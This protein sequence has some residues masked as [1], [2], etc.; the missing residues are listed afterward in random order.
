MT[1]L[2]RDRVERRTA[3]CKALYLA[4]ADLFCKVSGF[5]KIS[6]DTYIEQ[7]TGERPDDNFP[8]TFMIPKSGPIIR[9]YPKGWNIGKNR[10]PEGRAELCKIVF[11]LPASSF[12]DIE[13]YFYMCLYDFIKEKTGKR[14]NKDFPLDFWINKGIFQSQHTT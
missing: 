5:I 10:D 12:R 7:T 2:P 3:L 1:K 6:I 8:L 4:P 14:P 9:D 11:L 13:R